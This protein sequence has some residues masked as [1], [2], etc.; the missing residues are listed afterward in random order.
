M[1]VTALLGLRAVA[2][3][4]A[5][6]DDAR[7]PID[8][9][10]QREK[11]NNWPVIFASSIKGALRER[12]EAQAQGNDR[13]CVTALFGS[14]V[15]DAANAAQDNA[16]QAGALLVADALLLALPVATLDQAYRWVT[17]PSALARL[18]RTL[19]RFAP[20]HTC[21]PLPQV[22]D[23]TA[24]RFDNIGGEKQIFLREYVFVG[25]P[26]PE[27]QAWLDLLAELFKTHTKHDELAQ[28]LIL[29]S[30]K[31]FG[32]L[33]ETATS[34]ATHIKLNENKVTQDGAMFFEETLPPETLM[35]L[36]LACTNER[37]TDAPRAA[38]VMF[39]HLLKSFEQS[40]RFFRVGGNET[41]G[42]GWFEVHVEVKS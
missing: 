18:G 3:I 40:N 31:H 28:R 16:L 26:W 24:L 30:D 29:V 38:S 22:A 11:H 1:Q 34:V 19:A 37:K 5:G 15:N 42:M 13:L 33:A 35:L 8:L 2:P 7:G 12:L 36:P 20:G 41:T 17:C 10:I 27:Y 23:D 25:Q 4:H 9:P 32:F 39:E 6:C 21:P 14:A